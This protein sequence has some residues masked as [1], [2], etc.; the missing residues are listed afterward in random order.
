LYFSAV[1]ID[2]AHEKN[3]ISFWCIDFAIPSQPVANNNQTVSSVATFIL[4]FRPPLSAAL[5]FVDLYEFA[6][7]FWPF[8]YNM[9]PNGAVLLWCVESGLPVKRIAETAKRA[10]CAG[11]FTSLCRQ[12]RKRPPRPTAYLSFEEILLQFVHKNYWRYSAE[13]SSV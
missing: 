13:R 7:L 11:R 4:F 12:C 3:R 10:N 2:S 6:L 5:V 8:F 1:V 9:Q